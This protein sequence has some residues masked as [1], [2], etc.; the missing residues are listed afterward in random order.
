MPGYEIHPIAGPAGPKA[1]AAVIRDSFATVA[2]AFGL[3]QQNAPTNG[4][5][6]QAH[7]VAEAMARGDEYYGLYT[8]ADALVGVVALEPK[9]GGVFELGKLAVLPAQRHKGYGAA[10][11]DHVRAL[12]AAKG[13][14]KLVIG[15]MEENTRLKHWYAAYGFVHTGTKRFSHLPFTVGYMEMPL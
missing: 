11:M 1:A 3:T 6:T 8:G 14:T 10:L 2:A 5:F 9:E 4:A 15:I 13:G 12:A 7:H